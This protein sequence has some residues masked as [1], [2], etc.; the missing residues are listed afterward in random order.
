MSILSFRGQTDQIIHIVSIFILI[1]NSSELSICMGWI[2]INESPVFTCSYRS[3]LQEGHHVELEGGKEGQEFLISLPTY[4]SP[5]PYSTWWPPSSTRITFII[6]LVFWRCSCAGWE[7]RGIQK[8]P[9]LF[10]YTPYYLSSHRSQDERGGGYKSFLTFVPTHL[11]ITG[12]ERRGI[13]K[14]P[15]LPSPSRDGLLARPKR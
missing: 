4:F 3:L 2:T 12:R 6:V 1:M 15:N 11:I 5:T 10:T 9:S 7:K 8:P 14:L 13:Q